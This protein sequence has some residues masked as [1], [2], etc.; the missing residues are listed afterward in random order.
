MLIRW[1]SRTPASAPCEDALRVLEAAG[2]ALRRGGENHWIAFHPGLVGNPCFPNGVLTV[3]CHYRGRSGDTH[4]AAI[5]DIVK[6]I[7]S[8]RED[9]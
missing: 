2:F 6:A 1:L 4:P 7:R 9:D 3:S 8:L 5:R